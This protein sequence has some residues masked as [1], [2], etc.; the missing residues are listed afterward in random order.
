MVLLDEGGA[1]G[2]GDHLALSLGNIC[3]RVAHEMNAAALPGGA[4]HLGD[5]RLEALVGIGDHQLDAPQAPA[6]EAAQVVAL[7]G[8][9]LRRAN[10]QARDLAPA[11]CVD[12]H[13]DYRRHRDDPPGL[14][15][16]DASEIEPETGSVPL[17][18]PHLWTHLAKL[19]DAFR[20]PGSHMQIFPAARATP[21]R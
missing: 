16:F 9:G 12:G 21:G 8:L 5:G 17:D 11:F 7:E 4:Q 20:V 15:Q 1:D 10:G 18:Q 13:S 19:S 3:Q 6:R 2:G 14:A